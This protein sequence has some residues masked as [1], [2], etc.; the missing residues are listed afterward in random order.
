PPVSACVS[1]HQCLPASPSTSVCLRL[2]PPVSACV[3]LH[4]C[5]PASPST[6][7][8]LRLPPPVSACVSLHQCLP[9]SP[10]I[11]VY[12]RADQLLMDS[13]V[14]G[15]G[16]CVLV[17]DLTEALQVGQVS[18]LGADSGPYRCNVCNQNLA[19]KYSIKTHLNTQKHQ[20]KFV[21]LQTP[22]FPARP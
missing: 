21:S 4:Q 5:L 16:G 11:S 18:R 15:A 8:C 2:P 17:Q 9:A 3:S 13:L 20:N 10:S 14:G 12:L 7:V 6:S 22:S 1:L 19:S